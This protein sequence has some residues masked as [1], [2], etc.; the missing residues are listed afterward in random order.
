MN[1]TVVQVACGSCN[2]MVEISV[3]PSHRIINLEML[4]M[5]IVEHSGQRLCPH[6]GAV[7]VPAL[8]AVQ[9]IVMI[10]APVASKEQ[11]MVI[12]PN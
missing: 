9:G 11:K 12:S 4:S 6:C 5:F 10:A 3:N 2:Q 8:A 7:V 1:M